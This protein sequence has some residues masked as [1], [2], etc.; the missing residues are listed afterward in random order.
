MEK[1]PFLRAKT[2]VFPEIGERAI[3]K[4]DEVKADEKNEKP[5]KDLIGW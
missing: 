4:R 1:D 2:G 5:K 3:L